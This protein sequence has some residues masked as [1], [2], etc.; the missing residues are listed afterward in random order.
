MTGELVVWFNF[1]CHRRFM[2]SITGHSAFVGIADL[3]YLWI[4]VLCSTIGH[5]KFT[6]DLLWPNISESYFSQT[7]KP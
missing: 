2:F 7:E 4:V 3:V 1:L 6:S 5:T